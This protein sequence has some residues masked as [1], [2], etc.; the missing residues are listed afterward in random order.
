MQNRKAEWLGTRNLRSAYTLH[1]DCHFFFHE[2][3]ALLIKEKEDVSCHFKQ[4]SVN[5]HLYSYE[6]SL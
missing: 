5:L 4:F 1:M 3:F 6:K 2:L